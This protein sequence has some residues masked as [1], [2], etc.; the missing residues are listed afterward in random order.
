MN[1]IFFLYFRLIII[2]SICWLQNAWGIIPIFIFYFT[3]NNLLVFSLDELLKISSQNSS[4]GRI[5]GLYLTIINSAWIIAQIFSTKILAHLPFSYLYLISFGIMTLFF[6][7]ALIGLKNSPDPKYDKIP[8]FQ[9]LQKFFKNKNLLRAYTINFLL[10]IFYV[11][12][13]IYTPVYLHTHIGFSWAEISVIFTIMLIPFVLLQFPL[14]KYSDKTGE[15]GLLIFGFTLMSLAT[16]SLFFITKHAI[17]IWALALFLTR[18]GA[19]IIEIMSD[20]YFFRHIKAE[21][22]ELIGIYRNTAPV[23]YIVAPISFLFIRH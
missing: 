12:M 19:A 18:V 3:L 23:A 21:N 15:R 13:V 8:A 6:L 10:Q 1:K 2:F 16:M 5:R 9:S 7:I 14:G 17:W 20:V 11:C 4:T 22:D